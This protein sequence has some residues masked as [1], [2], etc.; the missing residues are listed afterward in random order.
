[1]LLVAYNGGFRSV[2]TRLNVNDDFKAVIK[3]WKNIWN[4]SMPLWSVLI[5]NFSIVLM[6]A[7]VMESKRLFIKCPKKPVTNILFYHVNILFI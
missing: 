6:A 1:M 3:V 7:T 2:V 5:A 4:S